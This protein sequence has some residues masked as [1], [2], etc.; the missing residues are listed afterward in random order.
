MKKTYQINFLQIIERN[1]FCCGADKFQG[2][3]WV[4]YLLTVG[5]T[6]FVQPQ[7]IKIKYKAG[8]CGSKK[9]KF[10]KCSRNS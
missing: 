3:P 6:H 9:R 4:S 8:I 7:E 5:L 10:K 2:K 1:W